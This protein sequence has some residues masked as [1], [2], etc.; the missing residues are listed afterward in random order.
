LAGLLPSRSLNLKTSLRD[1]SDEPIC[2]LQ[3]VPVL[4]QH[5]IVSLDAHRWQLNQGCMATS[6]V[7]SVHVSRAKSQTETFCPWIGRRNVAAV[8]LLPIRSAQARG[9]GT[10][11]GRHALTKP[12]IW[13]DEV[14]SDLCEASLPYLGDKSTD[15]FFSLLKDDA[16]VC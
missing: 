4:H 14:W 11:P 3:V 9:L 5:V 6:S 7:D 8:D 1:F 16:L 2:N 15:V 10:A 12:E 13:I